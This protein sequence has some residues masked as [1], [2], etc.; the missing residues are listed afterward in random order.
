MKTLHLLTALSVA[1]AICFATD[2]PV[3][4]QGGG[5]GNT[6]ND[7]AQPIAGVDVDAT[8]VLKVRQFDPRVAQQR[9][10]A[11]RKN[12]DNDLMRPSKLRKV[13]I[14]RL[15]KALAARLAAGGRATEEMLGLAGLTSIDYVFYYPETG[16][17]VVAGPA[18]G[19]IVDPTDRFVGLIPANRW[20]CWKT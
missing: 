8:G 10:I 6:I 7:F 3:H 15:E 16:D 9:L 4:G 11:A 19:F 18:E 2:S 20:S 17:I 14:N 5:G 13:S 1:V 12:L